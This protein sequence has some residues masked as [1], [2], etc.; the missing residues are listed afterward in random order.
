MAKTFD[1]YLKY[2]LEDLQK[3]FTDCANNNKVFYSRQLEIIFEGKYFHW[4]TNRAVRELIESGFLNTETHT[5]RN[6]GE[7]NL[8]WHKSSRNYK[9]SAKNVLSLVEEY[10]NNLISY[11]IG[12]YAEDKVLE[13]FAMNKFLL[14]ARGA[15]EFKGYKWISSNH[16]LDFIFSKDGIDYG[17]EVKNMLGYMDKNEFDLKRDI[18]HT[19]NIIPIFVYRMLPKNWIDELADYGGFSLIMKYQFYP[20][21]L[22]EIA[23]KI[24]D[25]LGLPV[26]SPKKIEDGTMRRVLNWHN[27]NVE[28]KK[29]QQN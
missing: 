2:A 17:I 28:K 20:Y 26:D 25:E 18:C 29:N 27:K 8:V 23:K 13:A 19:L 12:S 6:S 16:D 15:N 5:I 22:K 10:S 3:L 14:E 7:I 21:Y 1:K 24:R 4:I 9:R 11:E